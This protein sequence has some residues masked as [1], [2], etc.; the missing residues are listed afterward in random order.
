MDEKDTACI[1]TIVSGLNVVFVLK[2]CFKNTIII[3]LFFVL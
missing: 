2:E 3:F 1:A